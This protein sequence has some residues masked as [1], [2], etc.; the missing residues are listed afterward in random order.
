MN[1]ADKQHSNDI[2]SITHDSIFAH[3]DETG[4]EERLSKFD[5]PTDEPTK[6][7]AEMTKANAW[8][9]DRI[10]A[11]LFLVMALLFGWMAIPKWDSAATSEKPAVKYITANTDDYATQRGLEQHAYDKYK[12]PQCSILFVQ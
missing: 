12:K 4:V 2:L 11:S 5:I 7:V 6:P 3:L 9:F 8:S 1:R 10:F